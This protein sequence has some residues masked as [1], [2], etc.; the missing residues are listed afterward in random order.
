MSGVRD[1]FCGKTVRVEWLGIGAL[2]ASSNGCEA[3]IL[4]PLL[5]IDLDLLGRHQAVATAYNG[6]GGS[7]VNVSGT[8]ASAAPVG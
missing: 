7:T 4:L 3:L 1:R 8:G 6:S 2:C 5:F